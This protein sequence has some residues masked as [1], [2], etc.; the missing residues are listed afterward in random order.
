MRNHGPNKQT[1]RQPHTDHAWTQQPCQALP[2]V[3]KILAWKVNPHND[4]L[5]AEDE[6]GEVQSDSV[7][8]LLLPVGVV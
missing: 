6:S 3:S 8:V 5:Y 1:G 7:Q 4:E 2:V